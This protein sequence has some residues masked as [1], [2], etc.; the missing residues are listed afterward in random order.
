MKIESIL[1]EFSRYL[2]VGG[3]AFLVDFTLLFVFKTFVFYNIG[4]AGVYISTALGF[5]GGLV[6][7]YILSLIYVFESAKESNKGKNIKSFM[8]FTVIGIIGLLLTE[9]GMY[10]GVELF[11]INYL[12]VKVFVA[13]VVLLWNYGARKILVF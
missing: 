12:L 6:Y 2:K 3:T 5:I 11:A 1:K 9:L 4:I 13:G 7:N 10:V 8:I